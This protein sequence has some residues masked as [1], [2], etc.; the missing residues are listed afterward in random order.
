MAKSP[1]KMRMSDPAWSGLQANRGSLH[2]GYD[3]FVSGAGGQL[4]RPGAHGGW[5]V[6]GKPGGRPR[7]TYRMQLKQRRRLVFLGGFAVYFTILWLL[8]PTVWIYPFKIF[9]VFL[10]ELSHALAGL[11]T[12]G[13]V[14]RITLDPRQ[15]GT[16]LVNGGN[17][18]V[19]LS[20]G[21]LGSLIWGLALLLIA[22]T[23]PRIARTTL[24][25][26]GALLLGAAALFVRNGFGFFFS[27]L[28]GLALI[29]AAR[30]L[31]NG[32]LL[33]LLTGLGLTSALYALFDIRDD[34]LAQP[35][36][37]SDAYMLG[38]LTGVP[39][40]AWGFL[41]AGIALLACLLVGHRLYQK[42]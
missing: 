35:Y 39:T 32:G 37:Q 21:Y 20:A 42:A 34:I 1:I 40:L 14:Q 36:L 22:R 19:M 25:V 6:V 27:L 23:R 12:G 9:V 31:P 8:W 11:A 15:G 33:A 3:T 13:T 38:Q 24:I 16:T 26:L 29:V 2:A 7:R 41:W 5:G 17:P 18:F 4:G 28:F 10:H 30:K